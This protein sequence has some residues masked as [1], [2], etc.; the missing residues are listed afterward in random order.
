ML[1]YLDGYSIMY[2]KNNNKIVIQLPQTWETL[3]NTVDSPVKRRV[4]IADSE[5]SSILAVAKYVFEKEV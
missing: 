5:L 2:D 3:S 1:L 4:D